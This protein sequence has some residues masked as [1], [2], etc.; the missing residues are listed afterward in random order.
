MTLTAL[1]SELDLHRVDLTIDGDQ[2]RFHA[3][4]GTMGPTLRQAIAEHKTAL[5]QLLSAPPRDFLAIQPCP[6]CGSQE[7]WQWLDAR[8]LCRVCLI[9]DLPAAEARA[10]VPLPRRPRQWW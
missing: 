7:R 3:P 9:L 5:L 2:L 10:T 6:I 8:E 1:L 4:K